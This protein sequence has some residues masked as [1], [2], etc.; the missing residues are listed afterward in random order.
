[1]E[2]A[3]PLPVKEHREEFLK[4][5]RDRDRRAIEPFI[6]RVPG[7]DGPRHPDAEEE[8]GQALT[9]R[10]PPQ[11]TRAGEPAATTTH[12]AAQGV[13]AT[14][15]PPPVE[16][17]AM[18]TLRRRLRLLL[19]TR[20]TVLAGLLLPGLVPL[21]LYANPEPLYGV[22]VLDTPWQLFNV[23][24]LSLLTAT[25]ILVAF[26]V[27]QVN[28]PDRFPDYKAALPAGP[29]LP[30][31]WRWRWLAL[32]AMS[33]PVPVTAAVL[34][35]RDPS[36]AWAQA[37]FGLPV[38]LAAALA[39]ALGFAF[40][41]LL[42]VVLTAAQQLLLDP[43]VVSENLLPFESWPVF[44]PLKQTRV[45]WLYPLGDGL[46]WLLKRLGP[47][48]TR[49][50]N[51]P[52]KP[53][54]TVLAPGHAQLLLYLAIILAVYAAGF[55]FVVHRGQ[56]PQEGSAFAALFY[57]VLV[58]LFLTTLLAGLGFLLDYYRVPALVALLL[59]LVVLYRV[60]RTDHY[61]DLPP[62]GNP[63]R[64]AADLELTE[65]F[66]KKPFPR[67]APE[68]PSP[69]TPDRTRTLVVVTA[70]GG[71]IQ[72]SAW[73]C[74]VL[75]GLDELYGADFTRSVG[76]ISSVSGGSVGTMFY[77][78][79]G[80]WSGPGAPFDAAARDRV[81]RA[82]RSSG[83]EATGWGIAFP[84]LVRSSAPVMDPRVDRGW[85]IEQAW[86]RLMPPLPDRPPGD[87]R[88]RDWVGPVR[89]GKL[90]APVFNATLVETGQRLLISPVRAHPEPANATDLREF[91]EMFAGEGADPRV[92]TAAR[93]SATFPYVSPVSRPY[94]EEGATQTAHDYHVADGGY[95][96]NEGAFTA[97]DW[98]NRLVQH[99]NLTAN[100]PKRPF[101]RVLL[102]RVIPFPT[103]ASGAAPA[104]TDK[105]WLYAALGPLTTIQN[106]RVASQ[107]E[108]NSFSLGM[109]SRALPT[110]QGDT[111]DS[112]AR[113]R[114]D[115]AQA[116]LSELRTKVSVNRMRARRG[117]AAA[118]EVPGR[119]RQLEATATQAN[120]EA[121]RDIE[122]VWTQFVFQ[123]REG[124]ITPLSWKLT[125]S[126]TREIEAAWERIVKGKLPEIPNY[127]NEAPLQ[128]V[129]HFFRRARPAGDGG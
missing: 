75:T 51:R 23:T 8:P 13:S 45:P 92:T 57:A 63:A 68:K 61:Y 58:I 27:I 99:Y 86:G 109:L 39:V 73:T 69:G 112:D 15:P 77:L 37:A 66:D 55:A 18:D 71:G 32:L 29:P 2:D 12:G 114:R 93:L 22:L 82:A 81:N 129:D 24:W 11:G 72:A 1:M 17:A 59:L 96:D 5:V 113:R 106:V 38:G 53:V 33:L 54:A 76:V 98:I 40:G 50:V 80:D 9:G 110:P 43:A 67:V 6:Q 47:G 91:F 104:E 89:D 118:P 95:A 65:L 35:H 3:P 85:A 100:R 46:A 102:I 41:L 10:R 30:A 90:P 124:Y 42:L 34:V 70:A 49:Q 101:D 16:G 111:A 123:P 122:V 121:L 14:G 126:Q 31:P 107:A 120:Q 36:G 4:Y 83:L 108:R 127:L 52:G 62:E 48:Y 20:Y 125:A 105:G 97:V 117:A 26:R 21:A 78:A 116:E 119:L 94:R 25:L 79:H 64:P 74:R 56:V 84:D 88:V 44:R 115:V 60:R 28:A 128:T 7:P 103:P 19:L 87:L